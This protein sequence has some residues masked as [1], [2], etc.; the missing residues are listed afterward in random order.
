[1]TAQVAVRPRADS[2]PRTA[3]DVIHDLA[4]QHAI[5]YERGDLDDW[6]AAVSRVAGD[7]IQLDETEWLL[8]A[9]GRAEIIPEIENTRLHARYLAER[10][11]PDM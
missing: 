11:G 1:M 8:V 6:A 2:A 9:L 10:D 7:D 5:R 4:R 3:R